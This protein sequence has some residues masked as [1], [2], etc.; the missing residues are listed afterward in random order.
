MLTV[1]CQNNIGFNNIHSILDREF[2][3]PHYKF[4]LFKTTV[5]RGLKTSKIYASLFKFISMVCVYDPKKILFRYFILS[6]RRREKKW[7]FVARERLCYSVSLKALMWSLCIDVGVC[8]WV[9]KCVSTGLKYEM[10]QNSKYL[11]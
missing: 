6:K 7:N 10:H 8:K 3:M 9:N 11:W 1:Y 5:F 2:H 4:V